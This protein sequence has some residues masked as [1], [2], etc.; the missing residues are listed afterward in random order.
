MANYK[1]VFETIISNLKQKQAVDIVNVIKAFNIAEQLHNGQMRKD[2]E[3]FISHPVEVAHFLTE[4]DFDTNVIAAALLHDVVEDCDYT[5]AEV[6]ENFN[7]TIAKIVDGV[8]AIEGN[9]DNLSDDDFPKLLEEVKT[10][11][12]LIS[13][14]KEN[15][16]AFYIKFAD[17]LHNLTTISCFPHYKQMA[18]VKETENWLYPILKLLGANEFYRLIANEC[19]KIQNSNSI[20]ELENIYNKY[21]AYNQETYSVLK[22]ELQYL[23]SNFIR[24]TNSNYDLH[25]ILLQSCTELETYELIAETMDV[26]RVQDVKQSY[27]NKFP[28][29]KLTL[30][31]NQNRTNKELNTFLFDFLTNHETQK[32]VKICGFGVDASSNKPYITI[33]DNYRNKYQLYIFTTKNYLIY[34]NGTT[35]GVDLSYVDETSEEISD[36]YIRVLSRSNEVFRMPAKSTVLDFAFKIHRDFGFACKHAYLNDAPTKS[37]IYTRLSDGDKVALEIKKD[38]NGVCQNISQIRWIMYAKT[39]PAQRAL[40]RYFENVL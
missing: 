13:I 37:P 4:M 9:F 35:M 7:A 6:K 23:I 29:T 14:G 3:P 17:R 15:L 33:V 26:K 16:F 18:K 24:K 27:L 12:K 11:Q 38:E 21:F 22:E 40:V 32:I 28:I 19:F 39:E 8:T 31:F 10:Y 25:K 5:I 2:G 30:I 1:L 36:K 34:R 20:D